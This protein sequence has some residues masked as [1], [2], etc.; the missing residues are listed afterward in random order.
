MPTIHANKPGMKMIKIPA[1]MDRIPITKP[2]TLGIL[3]FL[4]K[5][6]LADSPPIFIPLFKLVPQAQLL[7]YQ[8][9]KARISQDKAN[10]EQGM[11]SRG[12]EN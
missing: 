11:D 8:V 2:L 7:R 10:G 5:H 3:K 4:H 12:G 9:F 6:N 1:I